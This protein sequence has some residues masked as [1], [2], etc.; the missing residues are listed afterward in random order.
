MRL[1][2]GGNRQG[3]KAIHRI[4]LVRMQKDERTRAYIEKKIS[5]GKGKLEAI[6][7]LKRY[8]AREVY[9]LLLLCFETR[10]EIDVHSLKMNRLRLG[11]KQRDVA[12]MLKV[13]ASRISELERE[14]KFSAEL[15]LRYKMLL[16][17]LQKCEN[18]YLQI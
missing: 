5:E 8:I 6:R 11:L 13:G 16:E 18:G 3:N 12:R 4:A 10:E 17:D 9:K 15:K 14:M 2:R 7:C 1:N